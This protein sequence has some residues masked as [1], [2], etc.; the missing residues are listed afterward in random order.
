M[1]AFLYDVRR[2][3][4][5]TGGLFREIQFPSDLSG[6]DTIFQTASLRRQKM[7][8]YVF[9][10]KHCEKLWELLIKLND[11]DKEVLCPECGQKLHRLM[12][13]IPFRIN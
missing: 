8:L 2:V 11:F 4:E 5:T 12:C 13:P 6:T 10:C 1:V 3:I 7:P 9:R